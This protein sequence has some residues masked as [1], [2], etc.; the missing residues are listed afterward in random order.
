MKIL[1]W[2]DKFAYVENGR[3][4]MIEREFNYRDLIAKW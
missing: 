3:E 2:N 4:C 1:V